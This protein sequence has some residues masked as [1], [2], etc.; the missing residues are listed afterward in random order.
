MLYLDNSATTPI[1]PEVKDAMLIYL[2]S[3]FGNPSGKYYN[4]ANN[5]NNAVEQARKDVS[6]LLNA[7]EKEIIFTAGATESNNTVL[8]G[9]TEQYINTNKN[10]IITSKAEH[11]AVLDVCQFLESK[12]VE[13]TYLNVDSFGRV[14]P[15]ELKQAIKEET[16]LVSIIWGN[17]E[18]GSLNDIKALSMIC[19]EA[20]V[21]FHTDATQVLGKAHVDVEELDGVSFLSCSAHKMH[22]PKGVGALFVRSDEYGKL[23]PFTP[24]MHGGG[25]ENNLRSGTYSVHNIVGFGEASSIALKNLNENIIRLQYLESRLLEILESKFND[26]IKLNSDTTNKI[27]GIINIR[28]LGL[29]NEILLKKLSPIIAAST[30]SACSS[31]KPSHVLQ[32]SGLTLKEVRESIRFSFSPYT[33]PKE[34]NI[35]HEL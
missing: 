18:L 27:P 15:E 26:H 2:T 25:Q 19:K 7:K 6:K 33:D 22:G 3:E 20:N 4:L 17:N 21:L 5:S 30:G 10:H 23:T 32:A 13:V 12:E 1:L 14:D 28:F 24:L 16:F 11:N 8:K 9:V 34:V 35:F 31:A 29:N